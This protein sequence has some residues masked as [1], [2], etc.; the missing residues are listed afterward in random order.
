MLMWL[1]LFNV[2][3]ACLQ[4]APTGAVGGCVTGL[5]TPVGEL[6][7]GR[8][9]VQ[10]GFQGLSNQ[11]MLLGWCHNVPDVTCRWALELICVSAI[12]SGGCCIDAALGPQSVLPSG[13]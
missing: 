9:G 7:V 4:A 5:R 3:P 13:G 8:W 10:R 2:G 6:A 1:V 11:R 12:F